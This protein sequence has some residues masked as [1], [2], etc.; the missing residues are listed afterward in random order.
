MK[1]ITIFGKPGS[2]KSVL[3]QKM[4]LATGIQ[5]HQLDSIYYKKSGVP[6][7]KG[8]FNAIHDDI[9][10]NECWIIDGLGPISAFK[11]RL[12][13]A[14]TLIYIDLP[15]LTCYWLVTKRLFKSFYEKPIG[16]PDGSSVVQGTI[17][18]FKTLR[19]CPTFWNKQFLEQLNTQTSSTKSLHVI[20]SI[21]ELEQFCKSTL[22]SN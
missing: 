18:S 21:S 2:G 14:D 12:E 19:L 11:R 5:L 20:K 10:A 15:Y 9:L 4:A 1:K 8:E 3:S 13:A 22:I 17:N 16:W 6:L 7:S